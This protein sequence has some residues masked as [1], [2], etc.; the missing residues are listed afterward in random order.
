M[1]K[2]RGQKRRL[3]IVIF[4]FC[5][6]L[7][8]IFGVIKYFW[9]LRTEKLEAFFPSNVAIFSEITINQNTLEDLG[10]LFP[11]TN[12]VDLVSSFWAQKLHLSVSEENF[13]WFGRKAGLAFFEN[14]DFMLAMEIRNRS[15]VENFLQNFKVDQEQ[16]IVDRVSDELELWTPAFSSKVSF[17]FHGRWLLISNTSEVLTQSF[18]YPEK[19]GNLESYQAIKAD[20]PVDSFLSL[21]M[22]TPKVVNLIAAEQ[23]F[24]ALKPLFETMSQTLPLAG[25][26]ATPDKKGIALQTKFLADKKVFNDQKVKRTPN[27]LMPELAHLAKKDILFFING[28]DL[29]EKYEHTKRFLSELNPQFALIFEGVLRANFKSLFGEDFDF[30]TEFLSQ[31]HGQYAILIDFKDEVYPFLEFTFLTEFGGTDIEQTLEQFNTAVRNAQSK[32]TTKLEEVEL[33]DGSTRKELVAIDATDVPIQGVEL[34]GYEYYTVQNLASNKKFSY[35]FVENFFVFS[36]HEEGIKMVINSK[37]NSQP[38]LA[39]NEDF[40]ESIL[41]RYSPSES[42]G[43]VNISKFTSALEFLS[44]A[45]NG[46]SWK[47]FLRSN[48]RTATFARKIFPEEIFLSMMLFAR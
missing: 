45:E 19:L 15:A 43:F 1:A 30:E 21:F 42:Y 39:E 26:T 11:E 10:Q 16:F 3:L 5:L 47:Q 37:N 32:F 44:S 27:Q 7:G 34:E 38:T 33:P 41:F 35:G 36:T 48:I 46:N 18:T 12:L 25:L 2:K 20:L 9:E 14:G 8:G 17:G 29:H 24:V 22:D 4:G 6:F 13:N 31:M 23:K 40:R 28:V